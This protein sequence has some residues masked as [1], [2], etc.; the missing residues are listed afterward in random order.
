[1]DAQVVEV[2]GQEMVHSETY[3]HGRDLAGFMDVGHAGIW[4]IVPVLTLVFRQLQQPTIFKPCRARK[5]SLKS[6]SGIFRIV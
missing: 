6:K 3:H 4:G 2:V 5:L 1:M